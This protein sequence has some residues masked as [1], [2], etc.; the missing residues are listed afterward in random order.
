MWD[1]FK[2]GA[3]DISFAGAAVS[4]AD[5]TVW[6]SGSNFSVTATMNYSAYGTYFITRVI[7]NQ[8]WLYSN[9]RKNFLQVLVVW[10]QCCKLDC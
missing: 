4:N 10:R 8:D 2:G 3:P 6:T 9:P 7:D 5:D 1:S